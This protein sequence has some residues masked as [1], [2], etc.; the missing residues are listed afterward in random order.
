MVMKSASEKLSHPLLRKHSAKFEALK[1]EI[2]ERLGIVLTNPLYK[3]YLRLARRD[4]ES[5]RDQELREVILMFGRLVGKIKRE[6]KNAALTMPS[7]S[8]NTKKKKKKAKAEII[9]S[10]PRRVNLEKTWKRL[11]NDESQSFGQINSRYLGNCHDRNY[12]SKSQY[13]IKTLK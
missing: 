1:A 10:K 5:V 13:E 4:K 3:E 8:K 12:P 6:Y 2:Q 11:A 9:A 7:T